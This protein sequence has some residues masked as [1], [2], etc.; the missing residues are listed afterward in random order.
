MAD[1]NSNETTVRMFLDAFH[2]SSK[3][4][5][6]QLTQRFFADDA[7]YQPLVPMRAPASGR[8]GVRDELE[9]Q[10]EFYSDCKCVIH[11]VG[12][13]DDCV[14]TERT[15]TVTLKQDGREIETRLNA[16]FDL[17]ASGK[18]LFW[19]EYYDSGDLVKKIGVTLEQFEQ[20]MA[21][22]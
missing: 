21:A 1:R 19:R 6:A 18:I 3:P 16:V 12:S 5:F 9:R 7:Q 2:A 4:D 11:R 14:F 15:D 20:I 17:D 22:R 13:G 10:Y 8:E